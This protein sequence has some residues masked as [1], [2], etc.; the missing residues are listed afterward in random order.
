MQHL[1]FVRVC[2]WLCLGDC[3]QMSVGTRSSKC[4]RARVNVACLCACVLAGVC[5]HAAELLVTAMS[6]RS[7]PSS[8]SAD[9]TRRLQITIRKPRGKPR[10]LRVKTA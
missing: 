8:R 5:A 2:T 1:A 10:K 3:V 9:S 7:S 6:G 4:A